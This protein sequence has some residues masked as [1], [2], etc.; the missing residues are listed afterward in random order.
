MYTGS[1]LHRIFSANRLSIQN[2]ETSYC[3]WSEQT[4][5]APQ[6]VRS[7]EG[8]TVLG[9]VRLDR[10]ACVSWCVRRL[11]PGRSCTVRNDYDNQS[12]RRDTRRSSRSQNKIKRKGA[13]LDRFYPT[14]LLVELADGECNHG[15]QPESDPLKQLF[16]ESSRYILNTHPPTQDRE[17]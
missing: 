2:H 1:P 4:P 16:L 5:A 8:T 6:E 3:G 9:V 12:R 14:A 17:R 13:G 15:L 10:H 7:G 11:L